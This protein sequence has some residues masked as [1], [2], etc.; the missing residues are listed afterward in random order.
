MEIYALDAERC[1][2]LAA[3]FGS[4]GT[5]RGCWCM[6]FLLSYGEVQRGWGD[7]NRDRFLA[8]AASS[9]VPYGVLAYE[10]DLPVG[11]CAVGPRSRYARALRSPILKPTRDPAE[12]DSVWFVPCFFTRVGHRRK[13]VSER[14]LAAAIAEARTHG[15]AAIEGFPLAG[16]GPF[17]RTD[18]YLGTEPLFAA[19]GFRPVSR[20]SVRRVV[21][22]LE[23]SRSP[24]GGQ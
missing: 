14:L 16:N 2:D 3:L 13:G 4:N 21:M 12:D 7:G 22:R 20:P 5:T 6:W 18:L 9:E 23:L 19:H 8:L 17:S 1:G 15:A 10:G 24:T 11:W